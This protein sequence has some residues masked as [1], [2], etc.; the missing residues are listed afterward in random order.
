MK[1][2][3]Q[4]TEVLFKSLDFADKVVMLPIIDRFAN[5][6]R[7]NCDISI[8]ELNSHD[9][10]TTE[11]TIDNDT[12]I[13]VDNKEI[14]NATEEVKTNDVIETVKQEEAP[15]IVKETTKT[16]SKPQ[17]LADFLF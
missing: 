14:E 3:K 9:N 17:S 2:V 8:M 10:R 12:E 4:P 1:T 11:I 6:I 5:A 13:I 16:I 15:A 7:T